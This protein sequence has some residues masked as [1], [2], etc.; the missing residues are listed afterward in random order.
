MCELC[1]VRCG[2]PAELL[3]HLNTRLHIFSEKQLF[4]DD[5]DLDM[6]REQFS[7]MGM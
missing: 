5:P 3:A 1:N 2:T 4:I 6:T 7:Q